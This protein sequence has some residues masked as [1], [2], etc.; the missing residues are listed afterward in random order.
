M[1]SDKKPMVG[2]VTAFEGLGMTGFLK[3]D[4]EVF[5]PWNADAQEAKVLTF[6]SSNK[7]ATVAAVVE[8]YHWGGGV[9]DPVC[10]SCYISAQNAEQLKGKLKGTLATTTI[11]KF[12]WWIFKFDE[13]NKKWYEVAYPLGNASEG[14]ITGQLNAPGGKDVRIRIAD[15][16]TKVH[17]TIDINVY[18]LYFEVVPAADKTANFHFASSAQTKYVT[19]WGMKI[20]TFAATTTA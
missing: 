2:Y 19:N 5:S 10:I 15:L 4:I 16:P 3:E 18:N 17:P 6:D 9:A 11:K 14:Y 12:S 1:E 8:S 20:G 7:K 13:E